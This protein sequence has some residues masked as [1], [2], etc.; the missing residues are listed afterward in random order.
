MLTNLGQVDDA[1]IAA[2]D[3][4]A[5]AGTPATCTTAWRVVSLAD[6]F[7]HRGDVPRAKTLLGT[8]TVIL[9]PPGDAL[10]RFAKRHLADVALRY[11][12]PETGMEL[13]NAL[14]SL[15]PIASAIESSVV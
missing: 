1:E 6:I 12:P 5:R 8:A 3:G 9:A 4:V 7:G 15:N 14:L 2:R 13:P 10:T 11:G